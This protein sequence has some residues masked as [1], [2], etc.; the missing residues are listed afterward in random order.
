MSARREAIEQT[1]ARILQA[2]ADLWL[3]RHYDDV[4]LA[5][6]ADVAGVSRQTVHRQFGSK[7][8]LL[9]ATAKWKGPSFEDELTTEPGDITGAIARLVDGYEVMGDANVRT[10]ALEG[11]VDAMDHV[12]KRGRAGH[13]AWIERT[14][15]PYLPA[16][17]DEREHVVMTLYA[18]TDVMV[19]KLLRRDFDRSRA[20]TEA[21]IRDLVDGVL[22]G[23]TNRT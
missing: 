4:T 17:G 2:M 16:T 20:D 9:V 18:A 1:R 19:W 23:L 11:R 22:R 7:D 14:F 15:G 13:R 21:A 12:L 6:V 5:D 3:E 8:E 10:L